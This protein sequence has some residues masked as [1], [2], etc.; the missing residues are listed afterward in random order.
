MIMGESINSEN[1]KNRLNNKSKHDIFS[2]ELR[3]KKIP[4]PSSS[5]RARKLN[6]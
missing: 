3:G 5:S 1:P 4:A 6:T 2:E